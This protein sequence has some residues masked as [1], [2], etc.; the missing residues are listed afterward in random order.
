MVHVGKYSWSIFSTSPI[1]LVDQGT[2]RICQEDDLGATR[3]QKRPRHSVKLG[4][5]F[6]WGTWETA[7]KG[8]NG[9]ND[10][11]SYDWCLIEGNA[12]DVI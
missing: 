12:V 10:H 3:S 1:S 5:R 8:F 6:V 7:G 4:A 11:V 9:F 2:D